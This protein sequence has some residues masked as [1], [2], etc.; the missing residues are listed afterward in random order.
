MTISLQSLYAVWIA[1]CHHFHPLSLFSGTWYRESSCSSINCYCQRMDRT[2]VYQWRGEKCFYSLSS[3]YLVRSSWERP[4]HQ[5]VLQQT[6]R[7]CR[8]ARVT[9][10]WVFIQSPSKQRLY[11]GGN[12]H[13]CDTLDRSTVTISEYNYI[14]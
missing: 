6:Q 3:L 5:C 12:D 9:M 10:N 1:H 4:R 7:Y 8:I 11:F 13:G 14:M 2:T